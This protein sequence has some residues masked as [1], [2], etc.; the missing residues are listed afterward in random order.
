MKG[1]YRCHESFSPTPTAI[2]RAVRVTDQEFHRW[3]GL[4]ASSKRQTHNDVD[5]PSR[6]LQPEGCL[7]E[8]GDQ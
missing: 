6:E 3:P 5:P 7:N 8:A 2:R 1:A 4:W